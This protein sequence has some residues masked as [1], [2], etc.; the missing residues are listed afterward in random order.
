MGSIAV[1]VQENDNIDNNM[2]KNQDLPPRLPRRS[3]HQS[4]EELE[5]DSFAEAPD[6]CSTI[7]SNSDDNSGKKQQL[8]NEGATKPRNCNNM[9][10]RNTSSFKRGE[11][12]EDKCDN[13]TTEEKNS[14][15]SIKN[16]D[17]YELS[18]SSSNSV[19]PKRQLQLLEDMKSRSVRNLM[20]ASKCYHETEKII[21]SCKNNSNDRDIVKNNIGNIHHGD[22]N[23][24]DLGLNK[25]IPNIMVPKRKEQILEDRENLITKKLME[26]SNRV[27]NK[28]I[29]IETKSYDRTRRSSLIEDRTDYKRKNLMKSVNRMHK[30]ERILSCNEKNNSTKV[31]KPKEM[32]ENSNNE[33]KLL[34][35]D[36]PTIA[37]R[38]IERRNSL[39]YNSRN[40]LKR[41]HSKA[42]AAATESGNDCL[43]SLS[44]S[45]T[46][47][48]P[49]QQVPIEDKKN[50][51]RRSSFKSMN[52]MHKSERMLS[53]KGENN[54]IEAT[55]PNEI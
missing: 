54:L 8:E 42:T 12:N 27:H 10:Q 25:I 19:T 31:T 53:C 34:A 33:H 48:L 38:R 15:Y 37:Q 29:P 47:L 50:R 18:K 36:Q 35:S 20:E 30:S 11:K 40:R 39:G 9:N 13:A 6:A 45:S 44:S 24:D 32:I 23:N 55:R 43:D 4:I 52:R 16:N 51:R 17:D 2:E 21:S 1:E 49:K 14:N 26:A 28:L 41:L 3:S 7:S 5:S 46:N 22:K